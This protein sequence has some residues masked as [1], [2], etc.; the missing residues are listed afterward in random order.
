MH[1]PGATPRV[2]HSYY[3]ERLFNT[4]TIR[5]KPPVRILRLCAYNPPT[6][7]LQ[8]LNQAMKRH[9]EL[10]NRTFIA[11]CLAAVAGLCLVAA[12]YLFRANTSGA[13]KLAPQ[14]E[15]LEQKI[16]EAQMLMQQAAAGHTTAAY[17]RMYAQQLGQNA[18]QSASTIDQTAWQT[19]VLHRAQAT[20]AT[21]QQ[22]AAVMAAFMAHSQ[23]GPDD[24][25]RAAQTADH[26][27][28]G[29]REA[30]SRLGEGS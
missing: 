28:A 27:L 8:C 9:E 7:G 22:F 6:L 4:T 24:L 11:G 30:A 2:R 12:W 18:S 29:I 17:A 5:T 25:R 3:S 20:A 26:D 10:I 15:Q 16:T 1:G 21:S 14:A 19:P 13:D 23:S